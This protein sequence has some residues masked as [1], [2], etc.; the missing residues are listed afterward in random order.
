[1]HGTNGTNGNG[2]K[3]IIGGALAW[4]LATC[5]ALLVAGVVAVFTLLFSMKAD[6]ASIRAGY[7]AQFNEVRSL[8]ATKTERRYTSDDAARD[9][10][11]FTTRSM[12]NET[13]ITALQ[14]EVFEFGKFQARIEEREKFRNVK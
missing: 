11:A 12:S 13:A 8:I 10:E 1:M 7:D 9:R 3:R 2:E 6:I 5:Q 4:V 14:R